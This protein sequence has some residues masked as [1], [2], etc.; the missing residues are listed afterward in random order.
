[1]TIV[2]K[3][4]GE[5]EPARDI[6]AYAILQLKFHVVINSRTRYGCGKRNITQTFIVT[7]ITIVSLSTIITGLN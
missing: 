3:T 5:G 4:L 1:M 2:L 6:H 7:E